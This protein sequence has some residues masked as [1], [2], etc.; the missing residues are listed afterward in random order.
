MSD[1]PTVPFG[2]DGPPVT[3]IGLGGEGVLR[4]R[5]RDMEA[6][7]V[8]HEAISQNITYFDTAPA[9]ENSQSYLG[10]VWAERPELR[11]T[12]FQTSKSAA[13]TAEPAMADLKNSLTLLHTDRL[14]LWQIHDLR[15]WEDIRQMEER[16]GALAAFVQA[17]KEG[18]V[19]H[20]GVTGHHDPEVLSHA[21][22]HWSLDSVLLPVN[23]AE[24]VLGGF[25][26]GVVP[27]AKANQMTVIGMKCLGG[28]LFIQPEN[29][30]TAGMLIRYALNC[31][32]D[33]VIVGCS[34]PDQVRQAVAAATHGGDGDARVHRLEAAFRP[35]A[36]RLAYYRGR[37]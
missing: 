7:N 6:R 11:N 10:S 18:M 26:D 23:P 13:R 21:V 14:D 30:V 12:V 22:S 1:I 32:V 5:N 16:G 4:T 9:Y 27:A 24:T 37:V 31:P 2:P 29:G 28:G 34:S 33:L 36:P 25:L 20:I 35:Y 3:R 17:K 15:T 8:I 19:R